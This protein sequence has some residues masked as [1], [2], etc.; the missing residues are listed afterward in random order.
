MPDI[1][2][3]VLVQLRDSTSGS[4]NFYVESPLY[5]MLPLLRKGWSVTRN[6]IKEEHYLFYYPPSERVISREVGKR[7]TQYVKTL[8]LVTSEHAENSIAL[9]IKLVSSGI[10]EEESRMI[11]PQNMFLSYYATA[12]LPDV[13]DFISENPELVLAQEMSKNIEDMTWPVQI[14]D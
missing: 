7:G 13:R 5:M 14:M 12:S 3:R 9:H 8:P 1:F 6:K 2:T 4:V 11:L 10:S